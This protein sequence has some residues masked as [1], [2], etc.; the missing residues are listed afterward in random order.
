MEVSPSL[1]PTKHLYVPPSG[2]VTTRVLLK[3]EVGA[4]PSCW[5]LSDTPPGKGP[6]SSVQA[7]VV[8]GNSVD[9]QVSV[10]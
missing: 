4:S 3:V 6:E 8:G 5:K 10:K 7:T 2:D 1:F 9:V